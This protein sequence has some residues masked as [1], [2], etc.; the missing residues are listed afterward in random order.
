MRAHAREHCL[1][2]TVV[3][4]IARERSAV[5]LDQR[6]Q[7]VMG[8]DSPKKPKPMLDS[9]Y[10][11]EVRAATRR[12]QTFAHLMKDLRSRFAGKQLCLAVALGR[13]DAA[14]S[15]WESGKR[16]PA[17]STMESIIGIFAQ[18]GAPDDHLAALS[19]RWREAHETRA[20]E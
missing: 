4:G 20:G 5:S 8:N 16:L 11:P 6:L 14:V 15:M 19:A 7:P 10:C 2:A 12:R 17:R 18:A 13:T 1:F 9:T 3:R